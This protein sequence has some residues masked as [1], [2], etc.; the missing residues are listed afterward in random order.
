MTA[1]LIS[2]TALHTALYHPCWLMNPSCP[3]HVLALCLVLFLVLSHGSW[4][5]R[6]VQGLQVWAREVG[7]G[8][9]AESCGVC[10]MARGVRWSAVVHLC[11]QIQS[12]VLGFVKTRTT[13]IWWDF[14]HLSFLFHAWVLF[15]VILLTL[16][17]SLFG[18]HT[19]DLHGQKLPD[20]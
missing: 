8:R 13:T 3:H 10:S 11:G 20:T 17:F 6:F 19:C 4:L 12:W 9:T 18:S 15:D 7:W 2:H 16:W 5:T 14:I 1:L